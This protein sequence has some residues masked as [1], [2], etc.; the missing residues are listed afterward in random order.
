MKRDSDYPA[1]RQQLFTSLCGE[2]PSE[3]SLKLS[4]ALAPGLASQMRR[5]V[6]MRK[7]QR[8]SSNCTLGANGQP[9]IA[10]RCRCDSSTLE[11]PWG[12]MNGLREK[13]ISQNTSEAGNQRS[14][15]PK[16]KHLAHYFLALDEMVLESIRCVYSEF[17]WSGTSL[18]HSTVY[19]TL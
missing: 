17:M 9:S 2:I 12:M 18:V 19:V 7:L 14:K 15:A 13:Y 4:P 11:G 5:C 8:T 16:T 6:G 3:I 10:I 1:M